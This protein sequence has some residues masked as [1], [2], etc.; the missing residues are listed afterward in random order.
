MKIKLFLLALLFPVLALA[1]SYEEMEAAMIRQD[2]DEAIR[3]IS[4][5]MGVNTVDRSGNTLL[6]QAIRQDIPD[7]VEYLLKNRARINARNKNGESALSIAAYI[8]SQKYVKRLVE[9]GAEVNFFGWQPLAYA[10]YTGR[11]EIAEYLIKHGAEVN[12]KTENGST[13]L[14]FASRFGFIE[15][16]KILLANQADPAIANENGVTAVDWAMKSGNTDIEELLRAAGG[17]S[18]KTV[19]LD[20]SN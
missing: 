10:A 17:R 18:G 12:A 2:S 5:G 4:R 1:G 11:T 8:G 16:V 3:L 9:A 14:F 13:A 15:I 19:E 20:L 6:I 7:L